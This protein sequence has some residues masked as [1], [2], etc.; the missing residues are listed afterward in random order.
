ME[1]GRSPIL[2]CIF[3]LYSCQCD[4]IQITQLSFPRSFASEVKEIYIGD[5][6]WDL[7]CEIIYNDVG[8]TS[9]GKFRSDID[10]TIYPALIYK[11][12]LS[13]ANVENAIIH[14]D[15]VSNVRIIRLS[16]QYRTEMDEVAVVKTDCPE[17]RS[18]L[19]VLVSKSHVFERNITPITVDV[20]AVNVAIFKTRH[21]HI[22]RPEHAPVTMTNHVRDLEIP[23]SIQAYAIARM[24][25]TRIS[26]INGHILE[27]Y[28]RALLN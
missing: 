2:F 25:R 18:K 20:K 10:N 12:I 6:I 5:V 8:N 24:V 11:D 14:H 22:V 28:I 26:A 15:I 13:P 4:V 7:H 21:I 17:Y 27:C 23:D 1:I 9:L 3:E 19:V 16:I